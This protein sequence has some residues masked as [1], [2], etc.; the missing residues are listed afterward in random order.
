MTQI[1]IITGAASGIGRALASALVARGE[2]EVV[3]DIDGEAAERVA[4]EPARH[5]PGIA[6]AA[7]EVRDTATV[8]AP[9]DGTRGQYGRLDVMANDVGIGVGGEADE[10]LL[11]HW[12]R[13]IDVNLRGVVHG[14][15]SAYPVMIGQRSGQIVNTASL[16]RLVPAPGLTPGVVGTLPDKGGP[17]D[18]P[19]PALIRHAREIMRHYQPRFYPAA[20]LAEDILRGIDRNA[21]LI[22]A[23]ASAQVALRLWRYARL[24][25][26]RWLHASWHGP[27]PGSL[28]NPA[29]RLNQTLS[30][31]RLGKE[32]SAT[33]EPGCD[34]TVSEVSPALPAAGDPAAAG[35]R[36]YRH[37][38]PISEPGGSAGSWLAGLDTGCCDTV[39]APMAS[40]PGFG[41]ADS[42]IAPAAF[43]F[44]MKGAR[45]W[46]R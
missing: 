2:T 21:A 12:D 5:G 40:R 38:A 41:A 35:R 28:P 18:L 23:S 30:R 39:M 20:Q 9:V 26:T 34:T 6:T 16:A 8:H 42:G 3:A 10:L 31:P 4:G 1:A 32:R 13:V 15:Q 14:V 45:P 36:R 7:V 37:P 27:A 44:R 19:Q 33:A 22:I 11:A 46:P 43:P 24:S 25:P 17:A 29:I